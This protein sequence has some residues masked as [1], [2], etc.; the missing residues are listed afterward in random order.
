MLDSEFE[1]I[2]FEVLEVSLFN[3]VSY[4]VQLLSLKVYS[5]YLLRYWPYRV[6]CATARKRLRSVSLLV[7]Q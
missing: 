4:V 1:I 3:D 2:R 7:V 6:H 5:F